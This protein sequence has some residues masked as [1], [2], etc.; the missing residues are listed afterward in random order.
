MILGVAPNSAG[1][2][3]TITI[4]DSSGDSSQETITLQPG[5]SAISI[6]STDWHGQGNGNAFFSRFTEVDITNSSGPGFSLTSIGYNSGQSVSVTPSQLD[7]GISAV[8]GDGSTSGQ[9]TLAVNL[10]NPPLAAVAGSYAESVSESGL[11]TGSS[12]NGGVIVDTVQVSYTAGTD[13]AHV[14]LDASGLTTAFPGFQGLTWVVESNGVVEGF[15]G[16]TEVVSF[17]ITS[18]ATI[19]AGQPSTVTVTETLLAA[20]DGDNGGTA[21]DLGTL[22]V[23]AS[24]VNNS[25]ISATD[26]VSVGVIDDTPTLTSISS[27]TVSAANPTFNNGTWT[28]SFGADGA[29]ST[30][31]FNLVMGSAPAG[32]TYTTLHSNIIVDGHAGGFEE[33]IS[34][35]AGTFTFFAYT[36]AVNVNGVAGEEMFAFANQGGTTPFFELTVFDNKSYTFHLDTTS[37]PAPTT[38]TF[39]SLKDAPGNGSDD[40]LDFVNGVG[41]FNANPQN[42]SICRSPE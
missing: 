25:A 4:K 27:A 16:S 14:T 3:V 38:A 15:Q 17:A 33:Q 41:T 40:F 37:L 39:S 34:S 11:P 29:N 36:Q 9:Q 2:R 1:E 7:F 21:S 31:P 10:V 22:S 18:D 6:D 32:F 19:N 5:Q 12:P 28:G 26:Q 23:I 42:D 35:A 13:N 30:T 8:D 20:I 24:D